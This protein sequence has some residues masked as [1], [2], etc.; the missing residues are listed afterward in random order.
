MP[1]KKYIRPLNADEFRQNPDG[2]RSTEITK[3]VVHPFLNGGKPTNIPSLYVEDG[4]VVEFSSEDK[5]VDAALRT[6]LNF[7][8]FPDIDTAVKA[9]KIRSSK[10]GR[11]VG[12]L[13]AKK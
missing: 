11:A 6:G 13:G 9:A 3:T 2:T 5:A 4:K 1:E 8:S 12:A 7:P 10:G